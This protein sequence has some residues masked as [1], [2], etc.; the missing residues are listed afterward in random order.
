MRAFIGDDNRLNQE[1]GAPPIELAS[2]ELGTTT[3]EIS[4]VIAELKKAKRMFDAN[5]EK[6]EASFCLQARND[7]ENAIYI[8]VNL[9]AKKG[10]IT[11]F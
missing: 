6:K 11:R 7:D 8:Q 9:C 10:R 5:P 3:T 2:L 1:S 4:Q